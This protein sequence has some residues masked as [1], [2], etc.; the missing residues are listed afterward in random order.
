MFRAPTVPDAVIGAEA[1]ADV[2]IAQGS[3]DG[4]H[5]GLMATM[6]IVPMVVTALAPI[7]VLAAGGI[8]D[9]RGLVAALALGTVG[10]VVGT[11]LLAAPEAPIHDLYKAAIIQSDGHD[12]LLTEIHDVASGQLWPRAMA[13]VKRNTLD[14]GM[15]QA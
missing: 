3:E 11:R 14:I 5:V 7:P 15:M 4:G 10:A 12:T 9:G 6:V 13:R 1:C 8:A 2:I